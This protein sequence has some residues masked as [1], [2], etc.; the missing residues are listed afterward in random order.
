MIDNGTV[1]DYIM[2]SPIPCLVLEAD[3][4]VLRWN[5][6]AEELFPSLRDTRTGSIGDMVLGKADEGEHVHFGYLLSSG[7]PFFSFDF[8]LADGNGSE[9]WS[10]INMARQGDG[11][12]LALVEDITPQRLKETHLVQ[13]KENAEKAS[14]TRS[15]FLA[16]ISHEIR[17]PIQTII[18][19][20]E[21]LSD[22]RLDEEQTEYARQVRFSADVLLT[23]IN[24]ILDFSKGEAGQ[25]KIE[26]IEYD[27]S[28]V[29]ERTIDLVSMEAH[30][31][32]L[33][34]IIDI[35]PELPSLIIGDPGRLQQIILNLVKNAVKFTNVGHI[36]IRAVPVV[37]EDER[38]FAHSSDKFVHFEIEDTG[39]GIDPKVQ[40]GLFREFFQADSSTTR[41]YGGSGLGLA[42]CRNIVDLMGGDIGVRS[43]SPRGAVF[44]FDLPLRPA[45]RKNDPPSVALPVATRFLLVDDNA[46]AL[47][48]LERILATLGYRNV[49]RSESGAE[50]L[51]TLHAARAEGKPIDIVFIDMV[52]PEMDGWRLAAEINK[53]REIN[54]AQ[55]YLMVP[56]GS[57][58]AD[59]K[60]KLLEW[61]N[62]YLYKP[63]KRR[64]LADL[65]RDH[66]QA[67]ID[68][69]VVEELV[70]IEEEEPA[71]PEK[72]EI[73]FVETGRSVEIIE[74]AGDKGAKAEEGTLDPEARTGEGK[75]ILI[76]EDH[77]VNRKLLSIVLEKAGAT[78]LA[79]AD[80][81]EAI[82]LAGRHAIDMVFMDIQMP[83]KN[84]YEAAQ[85]M[86]DN[87]I[88]CPII[89]CTASAQENEREQCLSVGMT[90]I[91]PKPFKKADVI[92]A[93]NAWLGASDDTRETEAAAVFD[94]DE[95]LDIMGGDAAA[96]KTLI[97][98][99]L[100]QTTAHVA[101][102][103]ED[104]GK[105]DVASAARTAHLIKGSSLNVT[106]GKLAQAARNV[107]TAAAEESAPRM[108][109][110]L[111]DL[112][113]E[114]ARLSDA[115]ARCGYAT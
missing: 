18:G 6:A 38:A 60:M 74:T 79:A 89:A 46:R 98:E 40:Q 67:S 24:D 63:I 43:N 83:R 95:L 47:S 16:N 7:T 19:M 108:L 34:L 99:Y 86:R 56:E 49:R 51:R 52:M 85:W 78:V 4:K 75:T 30:K 70:P 26:N 22:T 115:L 101:I 14:V 12:Y 57:F 3:G 106:A 55:L 97:R 21:L 33:E 81:Q 9:T 32:G 111:E 27:C 15:Q 94:Q 91:L 41:K 66:Y 100:D 23:L 20:M 5:G 88:S 2:N 8:S 25:L 44:W 29:I 90:D 35:D 77:P 93:L 13:A 112:K 39:I 80:G 37:R 104:I 48:V 59:A 36:V 62:G 64:L 69:E 45:A 102:L 107:E 10:R 68:L 53:D 87:G 50:A 105:G 110:S 76:A 71:V 1:G 58:G 84:G 92:A 61:F 109:S 11:K 96:T 31:K 17:T 42:I 114:Y 113:R 65:L 82:E 54:Q 72:A 103:E 73:K 28:F